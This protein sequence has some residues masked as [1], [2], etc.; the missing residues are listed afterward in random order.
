MKHLVIGGAGEIGAALVKLLNADWIDLRSEQLTQKTYTHLHVA[1]RYGD[2]FEEAVH[3]YA[4]RYGCS[5]VVVHSTVPVGTCDAHGWVHSPC[6]GVHP[7]LYDGLRT[8]V[9]YFGGEFAEVA[10]QPFATRGVFTMTTPKAANTEALKLWETTQYGVSIALMQEIHAYC[11]RL[12]LDFD[13]IYRHAN[14]TYNVGYELLGMAH[15]RRPVLKWQGEGIGGHCVVPNARL[16]DSPSA[17]RL[18][19]P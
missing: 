4:Q 7:N 8:F 1:M 9:K 18:A 3:T 11:E 14:E 10:A 16:L 6:R 13:L 17:K 5:L 2:L 19:K 15:V 12:G